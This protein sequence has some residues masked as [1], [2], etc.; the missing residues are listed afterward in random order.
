MLTN[1]DFDFYGNIAV[2]SLQTLLFATAVGQFIMGK[3][4]THSEAHS[5]HSAEKSSFSI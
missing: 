5:Q 2:L 3:K 4:Q 1:Q